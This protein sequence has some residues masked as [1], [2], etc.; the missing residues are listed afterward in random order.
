MEIWFI[1]SAS[2]ISEGSGGERSVNMGST[3]SL[4]FCSCHFIKN[5]HRIC[6]NILRTKG[7]MQTI[8]YA[9]T[10]QDNPFISVCRWQKCAF[11][12]KYQIKV[13]VQVFLFFCSQHGNGFLLSPISP[14]TQIQHQAHTDEF[15][16]LYWDKRQHTSEI[17][18]KWVLGAHTHTHRHSLSIHLRKF[19]FQNKH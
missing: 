7:G 9:S 3:R 15:K 14:R 8:G 11:D 10:K 19:Y 2:L 18:H 6:L 17:P 5:T 4:L 13:S 1:I 16:L 12:S